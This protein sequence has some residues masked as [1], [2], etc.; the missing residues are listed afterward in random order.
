MLN[1]TLIKDNI[2]RFNELL[3]LSSSNATDQP[4]KADTKAEAIGYAVLGCDNRLEYLFP[5]PVVV[6]SWRRLGIDALVILIGTKEQF[7]SDIKLNY[8]LSAL[9]ELKIRIFF[10]NS[11]MAESFTLAQVSRLYAAALEGLNLSDSTVLITADADMFSFQLSEHMPDL[12]AGKKIFLYNSQCCGKMRRPADS[13][14]YPHIPMNT[15]AMPVALWREVMGISPNMMKSGNGSIVAT[16]LY[17]EFGKAL[18]TGPGGKGSEKWKMDQNLIS[19]L[20]HRWIKKKFA[21]LP[22]PLNFLSNAQ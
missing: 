13:E 6:L 14:N 12:R 15:I 10:L 2:D 17:A 1:S 11:S 20:L 4:E 5:L 8:V 9:R 21:F 3:V 18:V 19:A 22:C 16:R 7:E